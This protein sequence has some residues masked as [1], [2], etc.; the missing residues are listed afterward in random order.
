MEDFDIDSRTILVEVEPDVYMLNTLLDALLLMCGVVS[1]DKI[2]N[3]LFETMKTRVNELI[4]E[5]SPKEE[6][7]KMLVCG[8]S[9]QK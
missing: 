4:P 7:E 9:R 3:G 1:A 2:L 8:F 5:A 6:I